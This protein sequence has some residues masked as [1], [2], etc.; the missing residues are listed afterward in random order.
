MCESKEFVVAEGDT[1]ISDIKYGISILVIVHGRTKK[2]KYE[3]RYCEACLQVI[4]AKYMY[5]KKLGYRLIENGAHNQAKFC[6]GSC[7]TDF[8]VEVMKKNEMWEQVTNH[9]KSHAAIVKEEP[10]AGPMHKLV[11]PWNCQQ[12]RAKFVHYV[13]SL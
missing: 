13:V 11:Q 6:D 10:E 2:R 5:S 1:L 9:K 7:L 8:R 3:L 4:K 12:Q